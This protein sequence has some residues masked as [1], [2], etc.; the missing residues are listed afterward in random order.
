MV[1]HTPDGI[2]GSEG[3]DGDE[4]G[5]TTALIPGGSQPPFTQTQSAPGRTDVQPVDDGG[6]GV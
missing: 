6:G 2:D 5:G 4:I 1:V 3:S